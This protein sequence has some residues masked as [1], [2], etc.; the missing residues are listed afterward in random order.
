MAQLISSEFAAT[1]PCM[2]GNRTLM[3]M[4]FEI[5]IA[6]TNPTLSST[7]RRARMSSTERDRAMYWPSSSSH[8][9][10]VPGDAPLR[11]LM[12]LVPFRSAGEDGGFDV[13]TGPEGVARIVRLLHEN[14]YRDAL[15]HFDEVAGGVLRRGERGAG[16]G[17]A[18]ALIDHDPQI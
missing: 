4:R 9:S 2:S 10:S 8:C 15:H 5:S 3:A 18:D 1:L 14:F 16:T 7:A 13:H 6:V 17:R 11:K 12:P